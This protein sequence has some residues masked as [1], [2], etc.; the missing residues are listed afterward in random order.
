MTTSVLIFLVEDELAIQDVIEIA[1]EEADYAVAKASSGEEAIK[2]LEANGADYRAL[3]TDVNLTPKGLTGWD[4]AKRAREVT[5]ELPVV[6]M[7]GDSAQ[8]WT[9][10]GVSNSVLVPKPFATAQVVT[11]VSQLIN[12]AAA[13]AAVAAASTPAK[14][15]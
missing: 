1:L 2:M 10:H 6:Y 15:D 14:K 13:V 3:I 7:T 8:E 9:S 11:A 5:A 4:V 12:A